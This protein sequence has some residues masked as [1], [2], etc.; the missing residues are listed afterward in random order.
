MRLALMFVVAA[1]GRVDFDPADAFF[2]TTTMD[3]LAGPASMTS[4]D[5]VTEPGLS[6]R[7]ALTIAGNRDGAQTILFDSKVF[8]ASAPATIMLD[9]T[10]EVAGEGTRIDAR[11]RGVALETADG[12]LLRFTGDGQALLGATV[13]G[14][15]GPRILLQGTSDARIESTA[16]PAPGATAVAV[17]NARDGALIGLVIGQPT[18]DAIKL[19]HTT[20]LEL[21]ALSIDRPDGFQI[22][23]ESCANLDIHDSTLTLDKTATNPGIRLEETNDSNIHDNLIDPGPVQLIS[24]ESSA[25]NVIEANILDGGSASITLFGTST[26]NLVM[27]NVM[28]GASD[29]PMFIDAPATGNRVINN[30]LYMTG[31]ISDDAP[32]TQ[33]ENTLSSDLPSDFVDPD[34]YDFR[35]S[36][37]NPAIDAGVD[38]GLDLLP[39]SAERFLGAAPDLGAVETR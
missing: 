25:N 36:A 18:A 4:V 39:D 24:L 21:A 28:I 1:C 27:R 10:L 6:L 12:P 37:D 8:P 3:R 15:T 26:D 23:A 34:A 32:D 9:S 31:G 5:E 14:G 33:I 30:T 13:I 16:F 19:D 29:E 17:I 35:L 7:E 38:T 11:N 2:V 22:F 20:G